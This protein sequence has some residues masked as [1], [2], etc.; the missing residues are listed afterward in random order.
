MQRNTLYHYHGI[1]IVTNIDTGKTVFESDLHQ[2]CHCQHTWRYQPGSGIRRGFCYRC[3]GVT[4]GQGACDTCY[5]HEQQ[6]ED[7]EAI[8]NRTKRMIEA[9]IRQLAQRERLFGTR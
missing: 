1:E 9:R 6:L 5:P 2:C 3:N 8:G 7:L 4:C